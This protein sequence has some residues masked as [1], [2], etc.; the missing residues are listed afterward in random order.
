[1][2]IIL[3][4]I[5]FS[6]IISV[7]MSWDISFWQRKTHIVVTEF[8]LGMG[9]RLLSTVE[10]RHPVFVEAVFPSAVPVPCWERTRTEEDEPG[11]FNGA[12]VWGR[13]SVVAAGPGF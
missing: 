9:P 6:A 5:I 1:M 7:S 13:I 8:S 2:K 3:A 10:E 11:T 4:I 12:S